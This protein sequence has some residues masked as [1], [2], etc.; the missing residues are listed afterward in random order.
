MVLLSILR[1]DFIKMKCHYCLQINK[2]VW[3]HIC[4][5]RDCLQASFEDSNFQGVRLW[6]LR[7][8]K[9][10]V[11]AVTSLSVGG[12]DVGFFLMMKISWL[13]SL[14]AH[15]VLTLCS[16][17]TFSSVVYFFNMLFSFKS[18]SGRQTPNDDPV[19]FSKRGQTFLYYNVVQQ[20]KCPAVPR[21]W[22]EGY[23]LT[24]GYPGS[25]WLNQSNNSWKL[26]RDTLPNSQISLLV[27]HLVVV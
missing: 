10:L 16:T 11:P 13:Y 8:E 26:R 4:I 25:T 1:N 2:M 17:K 6:M 19:I 12:V 22:E 20:G 21:R 5:S 24:S 18:A 23:T 7:P 15:Q 14:F 9:R 3:R 27:H